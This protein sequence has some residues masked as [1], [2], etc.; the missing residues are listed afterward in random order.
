MSHLTLPTV[1]HLE[2]CGQHTCHKVH[3]ALRHHTKGLSYVPYHHRD[4][5]RVCTTEKRES[6]RCMAEAA[7]FVKMSGEA[8]I[9]TH[10]WQLLGLNMGLNGNLGSFFPL[11]Y[12]KYFIDHHQN[13]SWHLNEWVKCNYE[14]KI[15]FFPLSKNMSIACKKEIKYINTCYS[16][17]CM[18]CTT[19]V[20]IN[21]IFNV[22]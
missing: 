1:K 21:K 4:R 18:A 5:C 7:T 15:I 12:I 9:H 6:A 20:M 10:G 8:C 14:L 17:I 11:Y 3:V 2:F 19:L 16:F 22:I 13:C